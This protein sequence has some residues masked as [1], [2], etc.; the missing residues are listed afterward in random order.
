[1]R[2]R[3]QRLVGAPPCYRVYLDD[4]FIGGVAAHEHKGRTNKTGIR[5]SWKLAPAE[6]FWSGKFE[7][8]TEATDAL[9]AAYERDAK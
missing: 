8:R 3:Y 2:I 5:W 7:T 4:R 9:I 1:M 6:C